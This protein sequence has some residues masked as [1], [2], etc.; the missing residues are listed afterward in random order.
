MGAMYHLNL[1]PGFSRQYFPFL[2]V[3][4]VTMSMRKLLIAFSSERE[5]KGCRVRLCTGHDGSARGRA[6]FWRAGLC[7]CPETGPR[8]KGRWI[9]AVC[10][11]MTERWQRDTALLVR[12]AS[13]RHT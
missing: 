2:L 12:G 1:T 11:A 5:L 10:R 9:A 13:V 8:Q 3:F 4:S 6:S 7:T